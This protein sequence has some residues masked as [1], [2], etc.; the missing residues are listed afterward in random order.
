MVAPAIS[1]AFDDAEHDMRRLAAEGALPEELTVRRSRLRRT[2]PGPRPFTAPGTI[3]VHGAPWPIG[4]IALGGLMLVT[5]L[6]MLATG[7]AAWIASAGMVVVLVA[8]VMR[9]AGDPEA[10]SARAAGADLQI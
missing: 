10:A 2:M 8:L 9:K 3:D 5:S 4:L 6:A 1:S 7:E